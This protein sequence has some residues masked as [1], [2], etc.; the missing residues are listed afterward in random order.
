MQTVII[1][2]EV[3]PG[4]LPGMKSQIETKAY[5]LNSGNAQQTSFALTSTFAAATNI[6]PS[7]GNIVIITDFQ[8]NPNDGSYSIQTR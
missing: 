3:A 5:P 1:I 8:Q 2:N 7:K 4:R 6:D